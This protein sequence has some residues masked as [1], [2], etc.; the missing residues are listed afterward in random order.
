[1][2][3]L[4]NSYNRSR[5]L[6][7]AGWASQPVHCMDKWAILCRRIRVAADNATVAWVKRGRL[8]FS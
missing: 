8:Y 7:L 4:T 3:T 5:K 1:M 6:A 2:E